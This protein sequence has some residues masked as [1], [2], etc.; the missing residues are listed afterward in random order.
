MLM[1]QRGQS[2]VVG[3]EVGT[4][5]FRRFSCLIT[6]KIANATITKSMIVLMNNPYFIAT[7]GEVAVA[8]LSV[9]AKLEKSTF[10]INRPIG[11]MMTSPTNDDTIFPKA[12]PMTMPTAM[13]M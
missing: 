2:L 1:W 4:G 9:Y 7:A 5:F 13:S 3:A 11:G 10:P 6:K 12:A 8:S